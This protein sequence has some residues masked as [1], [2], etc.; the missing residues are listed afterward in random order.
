MKMK[1]EIKSLETKRILKAFLQDLHNLQNKKEKKERT[2]L[3]CF[4]LKF[5]STRK[6]KEK[7]A[8]KTNSC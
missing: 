3:D 8:Q 7:T 5:I 4:Y 1:T 6:K 2:I